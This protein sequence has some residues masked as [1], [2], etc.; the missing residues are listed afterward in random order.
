MLLERQWQQSV[1]IPY[2]TERGA[3][4]SHA[5]S[6]RERHEPLGQKDRWPLVRNELWRGGHHNQ[7][8]GTLIIGRQ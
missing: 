6:A 1:F 5:G 7:L 3:G 4:T 8:F 2:T